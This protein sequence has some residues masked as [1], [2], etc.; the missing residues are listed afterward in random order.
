MPCYH[1]LQGFRSKTVNP[2]GKRSIVFNQQ[3]G[4]RDLRVSLPCGKCAWCRQQYSRGWAVRVMHEASLYEDNCTLTLTYDDEHLP[5]EGSL[6]KS[7]HQKFIKRLSEKIS[8]RKIRF[9]YCGEYGDKNGRPHF[10]TCIF[11]YD[12]K[13]K[14]KAETSPSGE[15]LY[16]S[17]ELNELW[18]NR[19]RA[20]IG[21]LTYESAA[22]VARYVLKKMTYNVPPEFYY[23]GKTPEYADMSR[24]PGLGADWLKKFKN[25]VYPFDF[26]V[27][28][29]VKMSPP[30]YY[31]NL[32][33]TLDPALY[34]EVMLKR[35]VGAKCAES[36]PDNSP[37]RLTVRHKVHKAR[38]QV[39]LKREI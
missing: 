29:N 14:K 2:T 12:F 28:D 32:L 36:D 11:N 35:K 16:E 33:K 4:F 17:E 10:H 9:F 15:T 19:G 20:R 39:F 5:S 25:D 26:V 31:D 18:Q 21:A 3:E 24:R 7:D 1:P 8:P 6:V 23:E 27:M 38:M 22:Y 37:R 30:K 34:A 13:D